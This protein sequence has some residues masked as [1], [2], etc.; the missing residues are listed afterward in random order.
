MDPVS[1][2]P[3]ANL[4][5]DVRKAAAIALIASL[6]GALGPVWSAVREVIDLA[7]ANPE[8]RWFMIPAL[9]IGCVFTATGPFFYFALA[10][11]A[12]DLHF[13]RRFRL[14]ACI[15]IGGVGLYEGASLQVLLPAI[16]PRWAGV[17]AL[18]PLL[19]EL[20][21]LAP[22]LLLLAIYRRAD[23]EVEG[24]API[25]AELRIATKAAVIANG[26]WFAFCLVRMTFAP[27]VFPIAIEFVGRRAPL[28][29]W[30]AAGAADA[31]AAAGM[32]AAPLIVHLSMRTR[33]ETLDEEPD[34][35]AIGSGP[36]Q[37][38][39]AD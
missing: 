14:L 5:T 4:L 9:V 19:A 22:I 33:S 34:M 16:F 24:G 2:H 21:N 32:L 25:S 30:L 23:D 13:P 10:R 31:F 6:L 20:W 15:G 8:F 12:E 39:E 36:E 35:L 3:A 37:E 11:H 29:L 27:F 38:F 7:A 1:E 17:S 18:Q 26:L 28:G